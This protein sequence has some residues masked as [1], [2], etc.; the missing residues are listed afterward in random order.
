M[1]TSVRKEQPMNSTVKLAIAGEVLGGV[2][3][4]PEILDILA[5]VGVMAIEL[6]PENMPVMKGRESPHQR[7]YQNRDI[8]ATARMLDDGDVT[9]P[10]LAYGAGFDKALAADVQLY[11]AQ[12]KLAVETA[13]ALGAGLVNHYCCHVEMNEDFDADKLKRSY[14][15]AIEAAE[16]LG[17]TITLENEAHDA[18][19][20][21]EGMRRI[22][23]AMGSPRFRT[24]FD[25]TNYYQAGYEAFPEAYEIL[26][27]YIAYIHI[28][29]GCIYHPD[30]GHR[31]ECL[32]GHMTGKLTG[33]DIY[34]PVAND[35]AVNIDGL[36]RRLREDG[37]DGWYTLEPHTTPEIAL[38]YYRRETEFVRSRL[39]N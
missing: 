27:D 39:E 4:L 7:L 6:W 34:Y 24:N 10:C 30:F 5:G 12:F 23:E 36:M 22:V 29:N 32:G 26:K 35:G 18:T 9:T 38:D 28:K 8:A 2:K 17:V 14:G 3:T 37:Y 11:A 33:Y 13:H 31:P 16:K 19:R 21:P 1:Q 15:P 25:A 20:S